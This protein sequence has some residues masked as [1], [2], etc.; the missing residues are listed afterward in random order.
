MDEEFGHLRH[1][2]YN[3]TVL[4]SEHAVTQQNGVNILNLKDSG[5]SR[6]YTRDG[7]K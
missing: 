4:S 1:S 5:K 2:D 6:I 3:C 7:L